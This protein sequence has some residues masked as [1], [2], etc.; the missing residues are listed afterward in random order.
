MIKLT[1]NEISKII[2]QNQKIVF[3]YDDIERL[4]ECI[5]ALK[6][7][8]KEKI[9]Y[10]PIKMVA[11]L[12]YCLEH[13]IYV[14]SRTLVEAVE[15]ISKVNEK[16]NLIMFDINNDVKITKLILSNNISF[17]QNERIYKRIHMLIEYMHNLHG[18]GEKVFNEKMQ[19]ITYDGKNYAWFEKKTES[20][21]RFNK[22]DYNEY[23]YYCRKYAKRSEF[24]DQKTE[25]Y[26]LLYDF[27]NKFY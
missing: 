12:K 18:D 5:F 14:P 2:E 11:H 22:S 8:I 20:E 10:I 13:I 25:T 7:C 15:F 9:L 23:E 16:E 27:V 1:Y 21:W 26:N 19:Y 6:N 24:I 3:Y 17:I 4:G